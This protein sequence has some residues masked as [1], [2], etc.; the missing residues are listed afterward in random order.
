[1]IYTELEKRTRTAVVDG[2]LPSAYSAIADALDGLEVDVSAVA[3]DAEHALLLAARHRPTLL[4]LRI[5]RDAET[6]ELL[7]M[8]KRLHRSD[9]ALT[10]IVLTNIRSPKLVD[11][12]LA[13]GAAAILA[14]DV[15]ASKL[16]GAIS[17]AFAEVEDDDDLASILAI[18][19]PR[20]TRREL[21]ILRLVAEGRSNRDVARLLWVTDQTVKFHL[22][23]VYRKLGV[24]GRCEAAH[25]SR[26][27]GLV[28][29]GAMKGADAATGAVA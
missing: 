14:E 8:L 27:H 2:T 26:E 7:R 4:V 10:T 24:R 23:N 6:P 16:E 17:E 5:D 12:V 9:L 3:A 28:D 13:A 22:A 1:M 29:D 19:R 15:S 21:E 18:R 11:G 25:W 20:L